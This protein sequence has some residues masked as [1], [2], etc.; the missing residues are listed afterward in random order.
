MDKKRY[1]T[2]ADRMFYQLD[3]EKMWLEQ[4]KKCY[5]CKRIMSRDELTFD[6]M[7][8]LSKLRRLHSVANCVVACERCN[9]DKAD[10]DNYVP[11]DWELQLEAGLK[12]LE[13]TT[14]KGIYRIA[15]YVGMEESKGSFSKW[16]RYWEK[17]GRFDRKKSKN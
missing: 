3:R 15:M 14:R 9:G 6:H 1:I 4:G 11:E 10:K 2:D 13:T 7:I 5:H 16:E 17:R 12:R 8:P